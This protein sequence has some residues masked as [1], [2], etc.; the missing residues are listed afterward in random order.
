MQVQRPKE[1]PNQW[2]SLGEAIALSI[3]YRP[4]REAPWQRSAITDADMP[5]RVHAFELI[6]KPHI[7][8]IE[9]AILQWLRDQKPP[10]LEKE[11]MFFFSLRFQVV[12]ALLMSLRLIGDAA[13]YPASLPQKE[14][15]RRWLIDWWRD[16]GSHYGVGFTCAEHEGRA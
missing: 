1:E 11:A 8:R 4:W 15:A 7:A 10:S 16:S 14:V 3:E 9:E 6:E 5:A 2:Y 13:P 12:G